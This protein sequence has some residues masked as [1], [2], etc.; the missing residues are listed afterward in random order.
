MCGITGFLTFA[1]EDELELKRV[2]SGMTDQLAHRGPDDSGVWADH[3]AGVAFGH[4]RLSIMDLSP[5][6]HQPMHSETGR[7]VIIFN[8]EVYNF[9]ALRR[10]LV[11]RGHSF[12]GRSD[13]EVILAA[14]EEWGIEEALLRFNGMFAFAIWDRDE[15]HLH[16]VRDRLGEKPLYY[17]MMG[18]SFLFGSEL[19][20]LRAHPDFKAAEVDLNS[21]ALYLK[22]N[23]VP[24]PNSVYRGIR[25][26]PPGTRLSL[27][28]L[29]AERQ[30]QL[31]SYWSL[32]R[33]VRPKLYDHSDATS[34]QGAVHQLDKLLRD[35]IKMRMIADVPLGAFLSGGIDSTAVVALMQ[36]QSATP[37]KTFSI[38][39]SEDQYDEAKNAARVARHLGTDHTE[40]YVSEEETAEVIPLLA[41]IYDEPFGDSSQMPTYVVAQ[42]AR[43]HVT[44]A[45]SGDGGDELFGGYKRYFMWGNLWKKLEWLPRWSRHLAA[46][47]LRR[48]DDAEWNAVINRL[49]TGVRF[50]GDK[51]HRLARILTAEDPV[52]RCEA[53]VSAAQPPESILRCPQVSE[54]VRRVGNGLEHLEFRHLMM[55]FDTTTFLPDDILVKVDRASMAV[56]LETRLPYL[57]HR[58]VEFAFRL[59]LKLKIRTRIGKWILREVLYRYV[60]RKL[61]DRPKQGFCVPIAQWLRGRLR[62]WAEELLREERLRREGFFRPGA[63]RTLWKDHLSAKRDVEHQ[64]WSI[65][66]FQA[67]LEVWINKATPARDSLPIAESASLAVGG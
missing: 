66:M 48:W 4:R 20:S 11:Q 8:G 24:S 51:L 18:K 60:P 38:G 54:N 26:L 7:Y 57:D 34:D 64:I 9:E 30:P 6:G 55:L 28:S 59:P 42:L 21:L 52:L 16:L 17:G 56:A 44:V 32:S 19:K 13:T 41:S 58:L 39:F 45:L 35:A 67:W 46:Q 15:R 40:M 3:R 53:V 1:L 22:Y 49:S 50:P 33:E 63:V 25:K 2:V 62:D 12:H 5:D 61:V 10:E 31:N 14:I 29:D 43:R 36:H 23:Y 37:V 27:A 47:A 65:L